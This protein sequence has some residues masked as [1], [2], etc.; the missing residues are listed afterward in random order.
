MTLIKDI[1]RILEDFAP[2]AWQENYD[3]SGLIVGDLN[4]DVSG[5]L[6]C[7]D[8]I[9]AVIDEA[10]A[11][12]CNLVIAHHPIVFSGLKKITGKNYIERTLLKAIRNNIAIYAIHTNLDNV[13][14]GVNHQLST[15]MGLKDFKILSAKNSLLKKLVTYCPVAQAEQVRNALFAAGAGNIGNYS[16]CSFYSEGTGTFKPGDNTHPFVGKIGERQHEREERMEMIFFAHYQSKILNALLKAHPYEEVAYD[17]YSLDNSLSSA[18]SGMIGMLETAMEEKE[19]LLK[20]KTVLKCSTLRHTH[21]TGKK[22]QKVAL[23]GGAGFFLLNEAKASG[24]DAFITADVKYHQF[25]DADGQ[26]LLVDAGHYETE[27]FTMQ[28]LKDLLIKK[29]PTFAIRLTKVDTNP[30]KYI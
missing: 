17:I 19:F 28:L 3:N 13:H 23:C 24:A 6:I 20:V 18:G 29:F 11:E 4:T 30:V 10:I 27:Q 16:E 9:E 7:L 1:V 8:S 21:F 14:H 25:F 2:P 22:I 12:K 15:V 26:I 5:I